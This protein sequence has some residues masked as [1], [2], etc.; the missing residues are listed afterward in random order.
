[1]DIAT[2]Q[3]YYA[4]IEAS[5]AGKQLHE[6]LSPSYRM[7][8]TMLNNAPMGVESQTISVKRPVIREIF[9]LPG[10]G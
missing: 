4:R 8:R 6:S 9:P 7:Q 1:M 5:K 10:Y 2:T 3:A